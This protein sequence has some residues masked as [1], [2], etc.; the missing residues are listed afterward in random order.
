MTEGIEIQ[1][2]NEIV[3]GILELYEHKKEEIIGTITLDF[4][5]DLLR[6]DNIN[7]SFTKCGTTLT[8][9]ATIQRKQDKIG[10]S[11]LKNSEPCVFDIT[12]VN[13]AQDVCWESEK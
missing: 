6:E 2:N 11:H 13:Y 10:S 12:Y 4:S 9:Y 1:L 8:G 5:R 3:V 7:F